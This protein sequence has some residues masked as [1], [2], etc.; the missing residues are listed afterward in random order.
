MN[1]MPKLTIPVLLLL[2][3][4]T[5]LSVASAD[6]VAIKAEDEGDLPESIPVGETFTV[7]ITED[8]NSVGAGTNVLFTL[9]ASGGDPICVPTDNESKVRYKPFITGTLKMRVLDGIVTVAEATVTVTT[10]AYPE[11]SITDWSNDKTNDNSSAITVN[12]SESI[13][14]DATANQTIDT[15]NWCKDGVDQ[16]CNFDNYTASWSVNRTYSVSVNATNVNGTSDTIAWTITVNDITPPASI[17]ALQNTTYE[18]TYINWTWTDPADADFS[19]V[20]VYLDDVFETNVTKG[21]QCYNATEL[22]DDTEHKISTRTVDNSGNINDTWAND[23]AR[24]KQSPD[25]TAPTVTGNMPTGTDVSVST[26]ITVTF[27]EAMNMTSAEGAF[28]INASVNGSFGWDGYTMTFDPD[29]DLAYETTYE[30]TLGTGANDLAGNS[31]AESFV[32]N[33]T[34]GSE[35]NE[36]NVTGSTNFTVTSGNASVTGSNFFGNNLTGWVNVT[37]IT[38]VTASPDINVS[39]P[40]YGLGSDDQ[41]VSGVIVNVSGGS[42]IESEMDEGNGTI[43]ITIC[44]D[45]AELGDIDPDTLAIWKY[46]S[47]TKT[48]VAQTST[49]NGTCVYADVNHLCTFALVGSLKK[50]LGGDRSGSGGS[51]DGTYPPGWYE[52]PTPVPTTTATAEATEPEL[53]DESETTDESTTGAAEEAVTTGTDGEETPTTELKAKGI[54]GFSA[55]LVI[56]GLL[57]AMYLV[58]RRRD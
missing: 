48:W 2:A 25:T 56:A 31:L 49:I 22:V 50:L 11:P 23:T 46:N 28:S 26:V 29:N 24:T 16:S 55:F 36:T 18:E 35:T 30:V 32:W 37:G 8:G 45:L 4:C 7:L 52:T 12:E 53:S 15:W 14:F 27:D 21:V 5:A 44:Y 3:L 42:N 47:S 41:I 58:L 38:N 34:T 20:M 40:Y 17:T 10:A 9:P 43:R 33:F 19:K 57:A 51:G 1:Q 13:R 39:D 54:P 6:S